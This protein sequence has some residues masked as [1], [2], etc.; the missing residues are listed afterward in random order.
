MR[1]VIWCGSAAGLLAAAGFLSLAF[2]ACRCPDSR[3]GRAM[4]VLAEAS[5]AMQPI[6]GLTS[7]ALHTSNANTPTASAGEEECVPEEPQPIAAEP[8][9]KDAALPQEAE[10]EAAP[11]VIAED[12]PLPHGINDWQAGLVEKVPA[13]EVAPKGGPIVMP[14]CQDDEEPTPP[15]TE[16]SKAD[17][18][19]ADAEKAGFEEWMKLF[20]GA[21]EEKRPSAEQLPAP[22]EE[23]EPQAEPKCQEDNH[24]HEHYSGCPR[25][26]CPY[27]G[28]S[29]PSHAPAFQSG[30]EEDSE[31]PPQEEKKHPPR[32]AGKGEELPAPHVDTMEF[33]KSDAGLN[34]FG[35]G[36]LH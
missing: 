10:A 25:V 36:P 7:L 18:S 4:Q 5:I 3:V 2:Y 33:R 28:K 21:K 35:P 11:I 13:E 27:T 31:A 17:D 24:L 26:T 19:G 30:Q 6:N 9:P 12:D 34:E 1:K 16:K 14:Y 29:Y 23:E 20:K 32:K 15:S 22:T 8:K